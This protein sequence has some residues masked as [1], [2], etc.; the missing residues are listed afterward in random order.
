VG[1]HEPLPDDYLQWADYRVA[2]GYAAMKRLLALESPPDAV[3][4]A[5][6]LMAVGVLRALREAG[7]EPPQFGVSAYGELPFA[8]MDIS[9]IHTVPLPAREIGKTAAELLFE[10]IQGAAGP[11]RTVIVRGDRNGSFNNK[12]AAL[13]S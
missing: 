10:R 7:A 6:N 13:S 4:S 8:T 5:N 2:G 3:V 11:P 9:S 1:R 12:T